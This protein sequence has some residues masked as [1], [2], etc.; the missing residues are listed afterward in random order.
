MAV[1]SNTFYVKPLSFFF[2]VFLIIEKNALGKVVEDASKYGKQKI[3][4]IIWSCP[5]RKKSE[6][7]SK[8]TRINREI[9]LKS[10]RQGK[11]YNLLGNCMH[12]PCVYV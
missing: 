4:L 11:H 2:F 1:K 9:K 3:C 6:T 12:G 7:K 10:Q 8:L 5:K